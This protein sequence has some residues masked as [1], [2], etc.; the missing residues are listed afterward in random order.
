MI[1]LNKNQSNTIILELNSFSTL[2]EPYYLFEFVS[3]I[4]SNSVTYFTAEDESG[5]KCRYNRFDIIEND[6]SI[7]LSGQ[8]SLRTGQYVVNIYEATASTISVSAT[9]GRIIQT[10]KAQVNGVDNIQNALK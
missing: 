10:V 9:T 5:Y 8:V 1:V 7:P 2:I 3:G 6:I 4:Y